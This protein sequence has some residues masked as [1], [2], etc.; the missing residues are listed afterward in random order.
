MSRGE[1]CV[2]PG[3]GP[4]LAVRAREEKGCWCIDVRARKVDMVVWRFSRQDGR[5]GEGKKE[6][7][8]GV[9]KKKKDARQKIDKEI[10]DVGEEGQELGREARPLDADD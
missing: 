7:Q 3:L 9:K 6:G 5:K 1:G 4:G 10:S 8:G 2:G